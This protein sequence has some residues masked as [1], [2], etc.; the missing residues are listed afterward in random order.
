VR[1]FVAGVGDEPAQLRLAGLPGGQRCLDVTE[2]LVE[3]PA[4]P[5]DLGARVCLPDPVRKRDLATLQ[6]QVADLGCSGRVG[7]S[8]R[9]ASRI[10]AVPARPIRTSALPKTITSMSS[11][12]GASWVVFINLIIQGEAAGQL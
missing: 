6:R 7:P 11:S 3:R 2:H 10:Q 1:S 5:A 4:E 9:C 8:G 12:R